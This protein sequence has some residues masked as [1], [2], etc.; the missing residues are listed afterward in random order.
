MVI[1]VVEVAAVQ[2]HHGADFGEVA[3]GSSLSRYGVQ[4]RRLYARHMQDRIEQLLRIEPGIERKRRLVTRNR[5]IVPLRV[6]SSPD[7][8][9]TKTSIS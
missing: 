5:R 9:A 7:T 8:W 4:R 6:P 1:V 3:V 2:L